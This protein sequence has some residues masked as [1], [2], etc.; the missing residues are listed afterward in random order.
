MVT[1]T[2]LSVTFICTLP[3]LFRGT[4]V[5]HVTV[6]KWRRVVCWSRSVVSEEHAAAITV[7]PCILLGM[8]PALRGILL[9][10]SQGRQQVYFWTRY[11]LFWD[12]TQRR[13]VI[14]YRRFGTTCV[15]FQES[16]DLVNIAAEPE[17]NDLLTFSF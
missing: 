6:G 13:V 1:R 14:V 10:A 12:I 7:M 9:P 5:R 17:I 3:V 8:L 4:A 11:A 2:R 15:I 16:A